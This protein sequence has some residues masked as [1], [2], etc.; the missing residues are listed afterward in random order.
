[1][2]DEPRNDEL[3]PDDPRRPLDPRDYSRRTLLA[4]ER[5]Y[6]AWW[7]TGLT[8]LTVALAAARVVPELANSKTTWPYT[9]IGLA[10]AGIGMVFIAY[11][12]HRRRVVDRAIR[13]G[14]FAE[15]NATLSLF[16]T[17]TGVLLGLAMILVILINP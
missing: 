12:E 9:V 13:Q 1:M 15:I 10:F 6:L 17:A 8:T 11:G 4:N 14:E 5:T 2:S 7:R 16:L 3:A